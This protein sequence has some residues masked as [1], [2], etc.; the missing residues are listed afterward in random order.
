MFSHR[1]V[2]F[3]TV[4]K[5]LDPGLDGKSKKNEE[6]RGGPYLIIWKFHRHIELIHGSN[7][8]SISDHMSR[9]ETYACSSEIL[10]PHKHRICIAKRCGWIFEAF[11]NCL[12]RVAHEALDVL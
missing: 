2:T 6:A 4:R 5:D 1:N 7:H 3:P 8:Q 9:P 11:P 12:I 10:S